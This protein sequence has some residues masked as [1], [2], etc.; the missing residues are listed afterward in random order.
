MSDL[1]SDV[2]IGIVVFATANVDDLFVLAAFFADK[3]MR[4][5]SIVVGQYLGVATVVLICALASLF[6]LAL[7][8]GWVALVGFVPLFL[9]IWKLLA[10]RGRKSGR[11]GRKEKSEKRGK[12]VARSQVLT[13]A[14][15]AIASGGD[16]FGIYVPLFASDL[17]AIA[18]YAFTFAV[19]TGLWCGLGYYLVNNKI[20]GDRIRRYGEIALPIVLIALGLII[21]YGALELF[22]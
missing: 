16:D 20:L 14:G 18:T 10:L 7:E 8:E 3:K 13:V 11:H 17:G 22:E 1:V 12:R 4:P 19:M 15:V 2:G 9:G 6:A 21:L 5:L